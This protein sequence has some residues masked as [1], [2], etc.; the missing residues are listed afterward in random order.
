VSDWGH[1]AEKK[2]K[3]C[4]ALCNEISIR[5]GSVL[6][7]IGVDGLDGVFVR[8]GYFIFTSCIAFHV[9]GEAT[10]S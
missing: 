10:S 3:V 6:S 9:K 7:M 2:L 1:Q 8:G 4:W 5:E